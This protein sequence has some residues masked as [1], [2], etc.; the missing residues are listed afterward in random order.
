LASG[1]ERVDRLEAP[2][3]ATTSPSVDR[4]EQAVRSHA[5]FHQSAKVLAKQFSLSLADACFGPSVNPRGLGPL[6]LWQSD[7]THYGPFGRLKRV[8]V[9]IDTFS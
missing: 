9:T 8:H 1:N 3:W 4:C 6:Q 2:L 7:V 5:F